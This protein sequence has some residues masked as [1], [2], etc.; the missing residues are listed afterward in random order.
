MRP[1][2][3]SVISPAEA[4]RPFSCLEPRDRVLWGLA[5][6]AGLR[7]GEITALHWD[8]VDLD[9]RI[10]RVERNYDRKT[11]QGVDPKREAG[12]RS[13]PIV[14]L[15]HEIL[16]EHRQISR[17]DTGRVVSLD[18]V[19]P[20]DPS[21]TGVRAKKCWKAAGLTPIGMHQARHTA[22]SIWIAAGVEP[23]L[24][25]TFLGHSSIRVTFD[26]YGHL[27]PGSE[28]GAAQTIDTFLR[29]SAGES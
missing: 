6:Y 10:L 17:R 13:I 3:K 26:I 14:S 1:K 16:T 2:R 23:K 18:G 12:V 8:D 5:L 19:E 22:A 21:S 28:K 4:A 25:Q 15:L 9:K 7:R 20:L 24:I 11:R 27:L 29:E